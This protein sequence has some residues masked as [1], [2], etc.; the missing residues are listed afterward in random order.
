MQFRGWSD[1]PTV[2]DRKQ[3]DWILQLKE[4]TA[5]R[6]VPWAPGKTSPPGGAVSELLSNRAAGTNGVERERG[7]G[8]GGLRASAEVGIS[9]S[10]QV[11]WLLCHLI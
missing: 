4:G 5:G 9:S 1:L 7:Q 8:R 10:P 3:Q 11:S 2:P 6:T